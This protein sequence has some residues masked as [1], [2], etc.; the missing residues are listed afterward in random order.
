MLALLE[1]ECVICMRVMIVSGEYPSEKAGGIATVVYDLS[2]EL[3]RRSIE[4]MIVCTKR[5]R[6]ESERCVF[7]SD[8]GKTPLRELSFG[9]SYRRFI[10]NEEKKWD[11]F[12]F[13]LPNAL[14]PLLLNP[15]RTRNRTI[16]TI[17]TTAE[18]FNRYVYQKTPPELLNWGEIMQRYGYVKVSACME[19]KSLDNA[20]FLVAGS[21]GVKS[22]VERWYRKSDIS[23]IN[24]GIDVS[25]LC[26]PEYPKSGTPKILFVGRLSSQKGIFFG[27]EALSRVKQDFEFLVVGTGPYRTKLEEYSHRKGVSGQFL[28]YVDEH[29]LYRLYA[30]ADLLLMPS[31]Y[32]GFP[33]VGIEG[34]GSGLPIAAFEEARV[35]QIVCKENRD[36]LTRTGDIEALSKTI[37][38]LLSHRELRSEIGEKNRQH[39]HN[40]LTSKK[41]VDKYVQAYMKI[42]QMQR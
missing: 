12:H 26:N 36:L 16:A 34:A 2:Q 10:K 20:R 35:E 42:H 21:S 17:H 31:L 38:H 30:S 41:M 6:F 27:L 14:G 13:H 40:N 11:V 33:I 39:V 9:N 22:E 25:K 18:G 3:E 7:L 28:G 32:E 8:W 15:M 37:E 23:V 4:H 19:R 24:N 29:T 1:L 5:F